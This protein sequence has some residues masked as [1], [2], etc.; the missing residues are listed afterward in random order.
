MCAKKKLSTKLASPTKSDMEMLRHVGKYLKGT[1]D[2]DLI[3]KRSYPG[4]SFLKEKDNFQNVGY[5]RRNPYEQESVLEVISDSDWAAD[6]DSRQSVS[7]GAIL[8]N[9]N[10]MH[11][12]SKRQ[13]GV[14]LSSCEAE[15]IAATSILSEAVFLKRFVDKNLRLSSEDDSVFRFE[16]SNTVDCK[17]RTGES[18]T[19]GC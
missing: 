16:Q 11:F 14:A 7:C 1:P 13:K 5:G 4:K 6:R 10:L 15:T 18:P 12:Q 19:L 8:L 9:G 2:V 17:E 3:H